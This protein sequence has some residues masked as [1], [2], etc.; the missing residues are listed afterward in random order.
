MRRFFS[1][2]SN[3]SACSSPLDRRMRV[4]GRAQRASWCTASRAGRSRRCGRRSRARPRAAGRAGGR[5]RPVPRPG[6]RRRRGC[7]RSAAAR[8]PGRR[9][10]SRAAA[11]SRPAAAMMP[12]P[13]SG[14][15][16]FSRRRA[17]PDVGRVRELGA[18]AERPAV[19]RRDHRHR[20]L[21]DADEGGRVDAPE[22]V[23]GAAVA[24]LRD[25]GAGR[26][27]AVRA[28]QDQRARLGSPAR[29]TARAARRSCA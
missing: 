16:I 19:D 13:V 8:S 5:S 18:A 3:S 25:V 2:L 12:R 23:V 22:R 1:G 17:D 26:E 10:R 7:G 20:Q 6:P 9:R 11:R 21:A 27:D 29:R 28:G 14:L 15:P 24:Q 4:A